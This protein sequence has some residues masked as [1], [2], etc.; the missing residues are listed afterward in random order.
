MANLVNLTHTGKLNRKKGTGT[1]PAGAT[2]GTFLQSTAGGVTTGAGNTRS[3]ALTNDVDLIPYVGVISRSG[4][5]DHKY[6]VYE[7]ISRIIFE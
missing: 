4:A 7:K 5:A 3:A 2:I 1:R 6:L